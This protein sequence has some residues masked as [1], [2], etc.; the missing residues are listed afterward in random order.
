MTFSAFVDDTK[1]AAGNLDAR[2]C[3]TT[4]YLEEHIGPNKSTAAVFQLF[5]GTRRG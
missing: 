1:L 2:F 4:I 3:T 5:S